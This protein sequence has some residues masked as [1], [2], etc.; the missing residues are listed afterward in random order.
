[1]SDPKLYRERKIENY[2]PICNTILRDRTISIKAKGVYVT[3]QG[4]SDNFVFSIKGLTSILLEGRK[5][6]DAAIDELIEHGYVSV[7]RFK[8]SETTTEYAYM[9]HD[10]PIPEE[11]RTIG[12]K[13]KLPVLGTPFCQN[14]EMDTPFCQNGNIPNG[15]FQNDET[16]YN[17]KTNINNN[18]I[19]SKEN[20]KRKVEKKKVKSLN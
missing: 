9:F 12:D 16:K 8:A 17:N 7:C 4:L 14:G 11:K 1:M 20:S 5:Q 13:R 19:Y 18:N 15:N 6:I 10:N 2:S 3:V